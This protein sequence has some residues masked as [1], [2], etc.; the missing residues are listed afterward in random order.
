MER[1]ESETLEF[2]KS[3]AEYKDAVIAITAMLNKNGQGTVYF[4][5]SDDGRVLGQ[6]IGRMTLKEVTQAVVDN[7][8]PK[9]YPKVETQ[10]I[11]GKDC[12][13]VEAHGTHGPYFAYGLTSSGKYDWNDAFSNNLATQDASGERKKPKPSGRISR[14]P[15]P[16]IRPFFSVC[17]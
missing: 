15:S 14:V 9:I 4:G 10:K 1:K 3:T 2:K 7:I 6:G 11:D 8:E 12:V 16:K 17:A 5:I 13:V